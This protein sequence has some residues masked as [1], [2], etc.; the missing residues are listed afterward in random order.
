MLLAKEE[1]VLAGIGLAWLVFA[2]IDPKIAFEVDVEDGQ[3]FKAGTS[4]PGSRAI[5]SP[6]SRASG[7][8]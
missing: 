8:P 5:P 2:K 4:W 1:G 3:E 6:S 7:R